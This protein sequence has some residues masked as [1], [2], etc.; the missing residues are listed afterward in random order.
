MVEGIEIALCTKIG[1][2]KIS[3]F[4]NEFKSINSGINLHISLFS[5][6]HTPIKLTLL[7][8]F[9]SQLCLSLRRE[10]PSTLERDTGAE[11]QGEEKTSTAFRVF[12]FLRLLVTVR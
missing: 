5:N 8:A 10:I 3:V 6:I 11:T 9:F 4:S 1:G 12:L 2:R 7:L